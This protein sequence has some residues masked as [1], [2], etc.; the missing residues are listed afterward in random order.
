MV[1]SKVRSISDPPM[2]IAIK[3]NVYEMA[4]YI[5]QVFAYFAIQY[6]GIQSIYDIVQKKSMLGQLNIIVLFH[7]AYVPS[8]H[9]FEAH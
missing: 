7:C 6:K 3:A 1:C 2:K 4:H 5:G 9:A 8:T